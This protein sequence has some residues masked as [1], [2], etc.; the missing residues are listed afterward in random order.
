MTTPDLAAQYTGN[1]TVPFERIAKFVRQIT[2]DV[3][4][5]LNAMDLQAAYLTEVVTEPDAA[6]EVK[7]LREQIQQSARS[8]QQLSANFW[9]SPPSLIEYLAP[10]F[11]EDFRER[12]AKLCPEGASRVEWTVNLPER[13]INIDIELIFAA[14]AELC[15]NANQFAD[16]KQKIAARVF[17]EGGR[18]ILEVQQTLPAPVTDA[19]DFGREPFV[20][21]RRGGYGLGLFRAR[22]IVVA[23]GGEIHFSAKPGETSLTTR[24]SLPFAE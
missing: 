5:G 22:M 4:N 16:P 12:L 24:V 10:I 14:L 17:A 9:L 6:E 11:V 23:H 20:S 2:H 3:R 1:T 15:K 21:T 18:F 8:L 19:E 7:R 13:N